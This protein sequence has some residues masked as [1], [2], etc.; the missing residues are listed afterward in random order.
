MA[1][2]LF[3][4]NKLSLEFDVFF[5]QNLYLIRLNFRKQSNC[6]FS[7]LDLLHQV[8]VLIFQMS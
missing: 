5:R 6:F 3:G 4:S 2:T 8:F 7:L 1:D